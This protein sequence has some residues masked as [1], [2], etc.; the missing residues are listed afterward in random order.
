MLKS[1]IVMIALM[2][3]TT[4]VAQCKSPTP[5]SYSD[6]NRTESIGDINRIMTRLLGRVE[7]VPSEEADYIR[8]ELAKQNEKFDA[9][10]L[11]KLQGRRYFKNIRLRDAVAKVVQEVEV[12]KRTTVQRDVASHL[13]E[14]LYDDDLSTTAQRYLDEYAKRVPFVEG[15]K[16]PAEIVLDV[17]EARF[18]AAAVLRC[19]VKGF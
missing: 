19:I 2:F 6:I 4:A 7:L 14:I 15:E 17:G 10:G 12:A 1:L 3:T 16:N 18:V 9:D 11:K 13:I 8:K 5:W